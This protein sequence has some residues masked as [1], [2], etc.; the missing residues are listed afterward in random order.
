MH[1]GHCGLTVKSRCRR[2]PGSKP[3]STEDLP[4]MRAYFTPNHMLRVK[5]PSSVVVQ[6]YSHW[7]G[8]P[9]KAGRG[10]AGRE[11]HHQ[12]VENGIYWVQ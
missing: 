6:K 3:D 10:P 11:P 8:L 1:L 9:K 7:P 5:L 12:H 4:C 2:I